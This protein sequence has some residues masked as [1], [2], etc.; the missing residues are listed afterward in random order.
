MSKL[1]LTTLVIALFAG[2]SDR[3]C[4]CRTALE[5]DVPHGANEDIEYTKKTVKTVSGKVTYR[6]DDKSV[7]DVVVE[8]YDV[9]DDNKNLTNRQIIDRN[10][11][12]TACVTESDGSFCFP[13]LPS[14]RYVIRAG[15]RSSAGGI[16]DVHMRVTLDRRWWARWLRL[17]V[18]KLELSPGT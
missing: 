17:E 2:P 8:I 1:F 11:R 7:G 18:I 4:L 14:G 12:R 5:D 13:G 9:S 16:N 10:A 3:F 15:T 6:Y